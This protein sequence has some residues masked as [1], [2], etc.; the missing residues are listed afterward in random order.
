MATFVTLSEEDPALDLC[1]LVCDLKYPD[2]Q[3][4]E[5]VISSPR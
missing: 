2:E 3:K 1:Q 4:A 5:K